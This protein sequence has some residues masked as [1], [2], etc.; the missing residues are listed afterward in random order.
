MIRIDSKQLRSKGTSGSI[1]LYKAKDKVIKVVKQFGAKTPG[2]LLSLT[3]KIINIS[4]ISHPNFLRIEGYDIHEVKESQWNVYVM[5]PKIEFTLSN[6]IRE[7]KENNSPITKYFLTTVAHT[8][9]S[10]V[11]HLHNHGT[12]HLS[13]KPQNILF[14]KDDN[15]WLTDAH[16]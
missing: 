8:L 1:Y 5:L 7:C 9:Y 10:V 6:H 14:D 2:E 12:A 15:I 16:L 13:I 3:E 4:I 11:Q